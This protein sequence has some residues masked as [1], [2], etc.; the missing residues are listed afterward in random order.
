MPGPLLVLLIVAGVIIVPATT[1]SF[2][3]T[4]LALAAILIANPIVRAIRKNRYFASKHFHALKAEIASVVTEHNDVVDYVEEIREQGSFEL[5]SSSTGQYAHLASFENTSAWNNRRDR[6]VSEYA[7]HV[8]NASLQ[9]VRNASADPLKYLMKYFSVKVDQNTLA[10][11]Q[12]VANDISR[13]EEA[14]ANVKRREADISAKINPPA[15]IL[16]HYREE[17]WDQVGAHLSPIKVPYPQY[18]FQYTSA[19]GNSSQESSI[20]LNTPTLEALSATLVDKIRWAKSAAGQRALMTTKLRCQIKERDN[21]ACLNCEVSLAVEPHLLLEVDHIIPV[22]RGGLSVSENLQTLC[23]KCN[24][25][26][27]AKVLG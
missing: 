19:G 14:V 23:W 13:L 3:L 4:V 18:K 5:G 8:H 1:S 6:K 26:K 12:S 15:F 27:G 7:P 11:V 20:E 9:V 17:F 10:D 16:K 2:W 22:S 25:S 24:R 21:Y